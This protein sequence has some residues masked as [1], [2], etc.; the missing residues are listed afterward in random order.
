MPPEAAFTPEAIGPSTPRPPE[1]ASPPEPPGP[2]PPPPPAAAGELRQNRWVAAA[3]G[4]TMLGYCPWQ[5]C[6]VKMVP[7][8]AFSGRPPPA[9]R[10]KRG[11]RH[12]P[13]QVLVGSMSA[14]A[15]VSL[16]DTSVRN[17]VAVPS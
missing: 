5:H 16:Y 7:V 6:T 3:G 8:S 1:G 11:S 12:V 13:V 15:C 9:G 10:V 17:A 4:T 14:L 2:G